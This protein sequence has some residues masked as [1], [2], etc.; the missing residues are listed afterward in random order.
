[1]G[2]ERFLDTGAEGRA[3]VGMPASSRSAA[4]ISDIRRE[5]GVSLS[6]SGWIFANSVVA[7]EAT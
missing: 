7:Y 3:S 1:M 6:R 5:M 4:E 2:A